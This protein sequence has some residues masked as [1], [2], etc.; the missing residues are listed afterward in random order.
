VESLSLPQ[1]YGNPAEGTRTP[2]PAET[3]PDARVPGQNA[4][5]ECDAAT[6]A[7]TNHKKVAKIRIP[8]A[9]DFLFCCSPW[10]RQCRFLHAG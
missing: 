9:P 5:H 8:G 6:V 10:Q 1:W 2:L 3:N 7:A 4:V